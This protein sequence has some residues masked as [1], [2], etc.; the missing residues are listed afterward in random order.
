M[1]LPGPAPGIVSACYEDITGRL[2]A[3]LDRL[4]A[5]HPHPVLQG[6]SQL[7]ARAAAGAI[8]RARPA[9]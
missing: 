6:S 9:R 8:Q 1:V 4:A 3:A 7:A 2:Q 5:G